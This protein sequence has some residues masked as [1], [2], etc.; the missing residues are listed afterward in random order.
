MGASSNNAGITRRAMM[1]TAGAAIVGGRL[2]FASQ[3]SSGGASAPLVATKL[4]RIQGEHLDGVNR[5]LGIRYAQSIAGRNRF[6]AP[7]PVVAWTGVREAV[8]FA[9]SSPQP[10]SEMQTP[11]SPA[12]TPP[13]YV[14]PGDDCLALN[15]WAP[16]TPANARLPVMVWLHGGGW[17]SGSGSCAIYDGANLARRGDVV[18]VTLN[19]RLGA[20]GYTDFSRVVGGPFADSANL[21][22][23]DIVAA[24]EWVRDNIAAFGGDPGLVTIFGESGGGWKVCTMLGMPSAKGL[25]HRAVV[26]SGPLT[27]FLTPAQADDLARAVLSEL[28]LTP[29]TAAEGLNSVTFEQVVAAQQRIGASRP[30]SMQAPGFPS[31]FW[32]VVDGATI[33]NHVFSPGAA[34]TSLG[35]P[36]LV[37]QNGTEF[38]LFMLGDRAAYALDDAQLKERVT[39]AFGETAA[40]AVLDTYRRA[41][42]GDGPS[43]LWFRL[44]S[45]YAMG[46]LNVAVLD[47]RAVPGAAAVYAYRF[48]WQTPIMG[49]KLFSPHTIEIPFVF[50]NATTEAGV[51]ITGGGPEVAALAKT[52]SSAWVDFA[53]TGK[54]AAPGLP[55]WPTYSRERRESMHL[56]IKSGAA[57]YMDPAMVTL[58]H[59]KLWKQAGLD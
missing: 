24:L 28:G 15:V 41:F 26:E 12:F 27:R 25:F 19:H 20:S 2:G 47:A 50:D 1:A 38:T 7:K 3:A 32:P 16:A 5:F 33:P 13:S 4:G 59:D 37:G 22:V 10:A 46:A 18:V 52:V 14:V 29:A 49:G 30:M 31:G 21:G 39:K 54:P 11:V 45:D 36:L 17:T 34:P 6:A 8:R 35:V 56:D 48:D 55:A 58:F 9:P 23:R 57:P 43:A 42:P 51:A 44:Y 40:P 53:R